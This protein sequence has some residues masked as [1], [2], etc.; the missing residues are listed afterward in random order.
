ME[1]NED[2]RK[3]L[4]FLQNSITRMN[5]NSFQLKGLMVTIVAA[6]LAV[7]STNTKVEYIYITLP[8]ILIFLFLDSFYL[9]QERKM[10]GVY[11]CVAG[12]NEEIKIKLYDFPLNNFKGNRYSYLECIFS[13]TTFGLYIPVFVIMVVIV[14]LKN[15]NII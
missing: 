13:W 10:R 5:T 4:E 7:Y 15:N 12:I 9:M 2:Q 14:L 3:H 11:K 8:V 1:F 6:L